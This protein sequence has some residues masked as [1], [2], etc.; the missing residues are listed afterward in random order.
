MCSVHGYE[1][2]EG[3]LRLTRQHL[4]PRRWRRAFEF[5]RDLSDVNGP[6]AGTQDPFHFSQYV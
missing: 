5:N 6:A 4:L 2:S 3:Y 1:Q